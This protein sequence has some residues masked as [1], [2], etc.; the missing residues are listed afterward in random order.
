MKKKTA[1]KKLLTLAQWIQKWKNA[2]YDVS[3]DLD[4]AY[5]HLC[6]SREGLE[7]GKP[8]GFDWANQVS[9]AENN[10]AYYKQKM[11]EADYAVNTAEKSYPR[12]V[13][14]ETEYNPR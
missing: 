8:D 12:Y 13:S 7:R 9:I 14:W 4:K 5:N 11:A 10:Y 6:F 2:R 1:K 3:M